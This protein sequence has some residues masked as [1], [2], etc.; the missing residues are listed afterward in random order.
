[1]S[2]GRVRRSPFWPGLGAFFV[3]CSLI[4]AATVL[5]VA[6]DG[7]SL[8]DQGRLNWLVPLYDF[9]DKFGV[10]LILITLGIGVLILGVVFR[11]VRDSRGR[12]EPE[13]EVLVNS[14]PCGTVL[15]KATTRAPGKHARGRLALSSSKYMMPGRGGANEVQG[16][17]AEGK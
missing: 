5:N 2:T 13:E 12:A 4:A 14:T 10:T 11:A 8:R 16:G 15:Y 3:G 1:M 9:T 7:M 17:T 6:Y